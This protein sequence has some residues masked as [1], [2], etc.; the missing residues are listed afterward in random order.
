MLQVKEDWAAKSIP[1]NYFMFDS[2]W[3]L[4]DG[5]PVNTTNPWPIRSGGDLIEW[6][7]ELN[8]FQSGLDDW[9]Q[10]PTF[11]HSRAFSTQNRYLKD[12]ND[13]FICDSVLCLPIDE[14]LF[15]HI[16]DVVAPW[17]PFVYEQDWISK[18]MADPDGAWTTTVETGH[19]WLNAMNAAAAKRNITIQYSMSYSPA[20]MHSS[21]LQAVTQI[22]G[23]GD[24]ACGGSQWRIGEVSMFFWALGVVTPAKT[25]I[26]LR[27]ISRVAQRQEILT[28]RSRTRRSTQ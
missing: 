21:T 3:Y 4:K 12:Y 23:S 25:P 2:W 19:E 26:G 7:P 1:A 28:A 24:Y 20:I 22:R 18:V 11:L 27:S 17:E 13:S 10:L 5:D 14:A 8:I 9:L 16:L 6:V 15:G